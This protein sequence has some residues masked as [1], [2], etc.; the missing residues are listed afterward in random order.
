MSAIR[1]RTCDDI[2]DVDAAEWDALLS[3]DDLQASHRFIKACRDANV[4]HATYRHLVVDDA[5]GVAGVATLSA[6]HASLDLMAAPFARG[7]AARVRG[8][9][10][11]FLRVP[12]AMCGLPVSFGDSCLRV[13]PGADAAAVVRC[14]ADALAGFAREAGAP[15]A[16]F[17]EFAPRESERLSGLRAL[18]FLEA[19]SLPTFVLPLRWRSLDAYLDS[20]RAGYRRQAVATLRAG[21]QAGLTTRIEPDFASE[22][23]RLFALY[24]QVMDRAPVQLE[25]LNLAFFERLAA[26]PDSRALLLEQDGALVACAVLLRSGGLETFLLAGIDYARN[27]ESQAYLNLVLAV[28]GAAIAS[29]AGALRL[30]QTS[31]HLKTRLGGEAEARLVYLRHHRAWGRG[32]LAATRT[33]LFPSH[34]TPVRRVFRA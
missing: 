9:W 31:E 7:A 27:R 18:G 13:R 6:M 22:C 30:G 24:G 33:A 20:M 4:E 2:D 11:S 17:K 29:G 10:P 5:R 32:L 26:L 3:D 23:P 15:V 14:V 34:P 21:E 28:V 16:C 25:R 19:P 1:V 12:I 8:L